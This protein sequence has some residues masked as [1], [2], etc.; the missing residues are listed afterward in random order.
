MTS[1]TTTYMVRGGARERFKTDNLARIPGVEVSNRETRDIVPGNK[2]TPAKGRTQQLPYVNPA[3]APA[4]PSG[5]FTAPVSRENSPESQRPTV[6]LGIDAPTEDATAPTGF[7]DNQ[8]ES[9][10]PALAFESS[11]ELTLE[12]EGASFQP[13]W[14]SPTP[15][16][17]RRHPTPAPG[18]QRPPASSTPLPYSSSSAPEPASTV[19]NRPTVQQAF[20]LV[21]YQAGSEAMNLP[22]VP[23]PAHLPIVRI[24]ATFTT[25]E[26]AFAMASRLNR[27]QS[28]AGKVYSVNA[29]NLPM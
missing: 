27:E 23:T 26:A 14:V 5:E 20:V 13:P 25:Y 28:S 12:P 6:G 15:V 18:V 29:V 7:E 10:E 21:S 8:F 22:G 9:A 3:A 17:S 11:D 2:Q 1:K 24:E 19:Q 16:P 4:Q